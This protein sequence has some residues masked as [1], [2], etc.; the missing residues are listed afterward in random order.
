M[1]TVTDRLNFSDDPRK[2]GSAS[3]GIDGPDLFP[4]LNNMRATRP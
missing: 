4:D 3:R 2:H 1:T